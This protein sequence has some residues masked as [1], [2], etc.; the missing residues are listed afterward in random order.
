[1]RPCRLSTLKGGRLFFVVEV[2]GG[3][4]DAVPRAWAGRGRPDGHPAGGGVPFEVVTMES[5]AD[6]AGQGAGRTLTVGAA[7][8]GPDGNYAISPMDYS[9]VVSISAIAKKMMGPPLL[10]GALYI[11]KA[12]R[13]RTHVATRS[14]IIPWSPS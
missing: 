1:M 6:P 5:Q 9:A 11:P 14:S 12:P 2:Q 4:S 8:A 10:D 13:C 3:P 7:S